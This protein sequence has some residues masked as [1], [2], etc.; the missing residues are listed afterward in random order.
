MR[1]SEINEVLRM[2]KHYLNGQTDTASFCRDFPQEVVCRYSKMHTE[3]SLIAHKILYYLVENGTDLSYKLSE[4]ELR[5]LIK[6][7][8][9]YIMNGSY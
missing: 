9:D 3:N 7:Q 1:K 6:K 8:Y 5:K 2:V 4:E